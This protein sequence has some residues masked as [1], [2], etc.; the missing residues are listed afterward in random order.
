MR[1]SRRTITWCGL[2]SA[3]LCLLLLTGLAAAQS[4][5]VAKE[6][7]GK[8]YYPTG[9]KRAPV[10]FRLSLQIDRDSL[11]G[12]M[13]EPATFGNGSSPELY[14]DISGHI[15]GTAVAFTKTYDGTGGV[16]HSVEYLG[17][18]AATGSSMSGSWHVGDFGGAF[19]ATPAR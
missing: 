10:P 16:N 9:D 18:I 7:E 6:W 17:T 1:W 19:S 12:Q 3:T 8:Y 4:P 13:S 11:S 2:G 15:S 5:P 14:A